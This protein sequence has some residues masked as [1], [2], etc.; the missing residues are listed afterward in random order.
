[1]SG[2]NESTL[3]RQ[4]ACYLCYATH[5]NKEFNANGRESPVIIIIWYLWFPLAGISAP[6]CMHYIR[7]F[8][9]FISQFQRIIMNMA[10]DKQSI[11]KWKETK[12]LNLY[13]KRKT[14]APLFQ[15][16]HYSFAIS[17]V[18][19][20]HSSKQQKAHPRT[21]STIRS[22]H[23]RTLKWMD[24]NANATDWKEK[25]LIQWNSSQPLELFLEKNKKT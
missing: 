7:C 20:L 6:H 4:I 25:R 9:L 2:K 5:G 14:R 13:I 1:M 19:L 10:A 3:V 16:A 17:L 24:S 22:I 11:G 18:L 23:L 21:S 8:H 15:W 12:Y